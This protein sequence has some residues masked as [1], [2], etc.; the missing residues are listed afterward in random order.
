[1]KILKNQLE[2][3]PYNNKDI[4]STIWNVVWPFEHFIFKRNVNVYLVQEFKFGN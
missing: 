3:N 4:L 1:M 2:I